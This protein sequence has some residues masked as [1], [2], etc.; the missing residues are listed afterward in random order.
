MPTSR[1]ALTA[2][3]VKGKIYAI[4]GA[5]GNALAVNEV[6]D[7]EANTWKTKS[8]MLTPR[9]HLA[10][11]VVNGL[12]YVIGGRSGGPSA[13]T[14]LNSNEAYDPET[15]VWSVAKSMPT[16]RGGI[17][18]ASLGDRIYVFGG[19]AL[20]HTIDKNEE[21]NPATDS[22]IER[23]P[24]RTGRHGFGVAT[25]D[26]RIYIIGGATSPHLLTTVTLT[27]DVEILTIEIF[28]EKDIHAL[29]QAIA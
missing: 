3:V 4:G 6:Y 22:W 29:T 26:R 13:F 17:A 27:S 25:V 15:D 24:L 12:I 9:E 7:P 5:S 1:G 8:P 16:K 11:A 10:S 23:D 28:A 2:Q 14:N 18:A 21:Y 20:T 19:E